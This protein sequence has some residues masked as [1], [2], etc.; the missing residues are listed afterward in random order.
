VNERFVIHKE[1]IK[2][3]PAFPFKSRDTFVLKDKIVSEQP[4]LLHREGA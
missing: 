3:G 2:L 1:K 4:E